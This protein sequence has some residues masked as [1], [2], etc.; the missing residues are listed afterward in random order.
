[1]V[2]VTRA[3]LGGALTMAVVLAG[4]VAASSLPASGDTSSLPA[5]QPVGKLG[6]LT[7]DL[8]ASGNPRAGTVVFVPDSQ[9]LPE[10]PTLTQEILTT[11]PCSLFGIGFGNI[12]GPDIE[13]AG[14]RLLNPVAN[15]VASNG[16]LSA[17][18][19][20]LNQLGLG[21]NP[22]GA[23]CGNPAGVIGRGEQLTLS[24]GDFF[25][26]AFPE[27][28]GVDFDRIFFK[29]ADLQIRRSGSGGNLR[30]ALDDGSFANANPA[31][32]AVTPASVTVSNGNL[33]FTSV[34]LRSTTNSG[35][36]AGLAV[37]SGT[38]FELWAPSDTEFEVDCSEQVV[39]ESE[40]DIAT[41]VVF[42][43]GQNIVTKGVDP[44][45]TNECVKVNATVEIVTGD[46]VAPGGFED[47]VF[48][49]NTLEDGLNSTVVIDWAPISPDKANEPTQ[50]DFVGDGV[51]YIDALWCDSFTAVAGDPT[52]FTGTLPL[53]TEAGNR[54]GRA[55]W[56]LVSSTQVMIGDE[57]FRTEVFYG[58]GD[59]RVR[60]VS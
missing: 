60:T 3:R 1:M 4:V 45:F 42:L 55:P 24:L 39:Q 17:A 50:V 35:G 6:T 5:A 10:A 27:M 12:T 31:L 15:L 54:D 43:R 28:V 33:G 40:G 44:E 7:V 49:D 41:R 46:T 37:E 26:G 29:S 59:P 48:W 52:Q 56:C 51:E 18:V 22:S 2:A 11:Q 23:N 9:R 47:Y 36:D 13:V 25:T 57:V 32:P 30:F 20:Q 8:N 53:Y 34:K 21:V 38:T 58:S 14:Q 19:I 16:N